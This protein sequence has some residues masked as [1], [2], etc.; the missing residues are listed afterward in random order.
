MER[1]QVAD[2]ALSPRAAPHGGGGFGRHTRAARCCRRRSAWVAGAAAVQAERAA[3]SAPRFEL[4]TVV[5]Q[6]ARAREAKH[7]TRG[8]PGREAGDPGA[9]REPN[10]APSCRGGHAGCCPL[11]LTSARRPFEPAAGPA[12]DNGGSHADGRWRAGLWRRRTGGGELNPRA[13]RVNDHAPGNASLASRRP[14]TDKPK[15]P[16]VP[17]TCHVCVGDQRRRGLSVFVSERR[18]VCNSGGSGS[19]QDEGRGGNKAGA[20]SGRGWCGLC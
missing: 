11:S 4:E 14:P 9:G 3:A 2:G 18:T 6:T 5:G 12:D 8:V 1:Q 20:F 15:A 16:A 19:T 10:A 17:A 7:V 13:G